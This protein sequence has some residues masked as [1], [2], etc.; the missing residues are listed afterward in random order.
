MAWLSHHACLH[1]VRTILLPG[2]VACWSKISCQI[3]VET[4]ETCFSLFLISYAESFMWH[5]DV[6][7]RKYAWI[8][9]RLTGLSFV[10][11]PEFAKMMYASWGL[12]QFA[13][14]HMK[15]SRG[16]KECSLH[17]IHLVSFLFPISMPS[18]WTN[19]WSNGPS[20]IA[21]DAQKPRHFAVI[22]LYWFF[23]DK[24]FCKCYHF[25]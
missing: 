10:V 15:W 22:I 9:I 18:S 21:S 5:Y 3:L 11:F 1:S 4:M 16:T 17:S 2:L 14:L 13:I 6:N 24:K 8:I 7:Y 19:P 12:P 25:L 20:S 23:V